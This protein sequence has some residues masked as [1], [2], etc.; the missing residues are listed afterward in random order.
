M[1]GGHSPMS[2]L[3]PRPWW[4][5][6]F[7]SKSNFENEGIGFLLNIKFWVDYSLY[8]ARP[9]VQTVQCRIYMYVWGAEN[10][11]VENVTPAGSGVTHVFHCRFFSRSWSMGFILSGRRHAKEVP[12]LCEFSGITPFWSRPRLIKAKLQ[13]LT[14]DHISA[15]LVGHNPVNQNVCCTLFN[16]FFNGFGTVA[17][18]L[19]LIYSLQY[20]C[21][22][23]F[24]Y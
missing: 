11:G 8:G 16:T 18:L 23:A 14:V 21:Q 17:A 12:F 15:E 7:R 20:Y 6:S 4:W 19:A 2:P 24:V 5:S 13:K 10:A 1:T 9:T 22:F 3:W